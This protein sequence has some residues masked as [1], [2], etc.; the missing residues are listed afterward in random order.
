LINKTTKKEVASN[1]VIERVYVLI[2]DL[3]V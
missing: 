2:S 1:D 3:K